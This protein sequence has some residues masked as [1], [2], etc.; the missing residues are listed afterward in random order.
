[1]KSALQRL[2]NKE[3]ENE[4]RIFKVFN[5]FKKEMQKIFNNIHKKQTA[6]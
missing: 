3:D 4:I 1:M 2:L 6:E 5:N